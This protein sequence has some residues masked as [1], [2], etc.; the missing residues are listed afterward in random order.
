VA[1]AT[2]TEKVMQVY[3]SFWNARMKKSACGG[4]ATLPNWLYLV[5]NFAHHAEHPKVID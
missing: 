5:I 1:L 4:I 3:A 2:G